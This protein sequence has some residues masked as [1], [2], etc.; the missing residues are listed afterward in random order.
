MEIIKR[1]P[2]HVINSFRALY[3]ES[4][5]NYIPDWEEEVMTIVRENA[6]ISK[7]QDD[8]IQL[9]KRYYCIAGAHAAIQQTNNDINAKQ[10]ETYMSMFRNNLEAVKNAQEKN[11]STANSEQKY[12]LNTTSR[13]FNAEFFK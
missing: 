9:L 10:S 13:V 11:R 1:I 2:A 5:E 3:G 8:T 7:V 6:D 12:I 4:I